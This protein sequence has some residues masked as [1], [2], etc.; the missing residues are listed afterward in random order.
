MQ[1]FYTHSSNSTF[2]SPALPT[3]SQ[4]PARSPAAKTVPSTGQLLVILQD[5][6]RVQGN[7]EPSLH[8]Q[9]ITCSLSVVFYPHLQSHEAAG[10]E[11]SSLSPVA[12]AQSLAHRRGS[13]I[14]HDGCRKLRGRIGG[15]VSVLQVY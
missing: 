1:S 11:S 13:A 5:S 6:T 15:P 8:I 12:S 9:K 14:E 10:T 2:R 7:S 4:H 3:G